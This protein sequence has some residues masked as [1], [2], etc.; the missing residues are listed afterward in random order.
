[1]LVD[2]K[3]GWADTAKIVVPAMIAYTYV[4]YFQNLPKFPPLDGAQLAHFK[5]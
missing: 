5:E 4:I 2:H 1:M 3:A